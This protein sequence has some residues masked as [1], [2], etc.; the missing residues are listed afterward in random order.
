MSVVVG[1]GIKES[2]EGEVN[3][4]KYIGRNWLNRVWWEGGIEKGIDGGVD[5]RENGGRNGLIQVWLKGWIEEDMERGMNWREDGWRDGLKR[6][7]RD[8]WIEDSVVGPVMDWRE[9]VG[10]D[11]LKKESIQGSNVELYSCAK[12][13]TCVKVS[14]FTVDLINIC[15]FI[16][17]NCFTY[18]E[19]SLV[20]W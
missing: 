18:V 4:R 10:T 19:K 20:H 14:V 7:W 3:W 17:N 12:K 1:K 6:V 9:Y 2:M 13:E 16:V 5:W 11:W 8:G 15:L